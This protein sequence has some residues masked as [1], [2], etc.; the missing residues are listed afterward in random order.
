MLI[1]SATAADLDAILRIQ[2]ACPEA[3]RWS[4]RD[5]L[6]YETEVAEEAGSVGGFLV[7]RQV[8]PGEYEILNL[9]VDPA[10]RRRGIA[11]RLLEQTLETRPGKYFLE[12]RES[13]TAARNFYIS[14]GFQIAGRRPSYYEDPSEAA[15]V[16][17]S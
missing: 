2:E 1:R 13:N 11:R 4:P 15:I 6:A 8:A 3:A 9:A 10:L 7:T 17:E 16:M 12:V 5:F 14:M